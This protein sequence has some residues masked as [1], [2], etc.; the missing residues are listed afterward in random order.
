VIQVLRRTSPLALLATLAVA[1]AGCGTPR[2]DNGEPGG[3]ACQTCHGGLSG[4][5]APPR[6]TT[7][8][9]STGAL[10]VGAHQ[11]HLAD[12]AFRK[13]VACGECH[14][15]PR[16]TD[17]A[18]GVVDVVFG[19]LATHGGAPAAFA[20]D[21]PTG[22]CSGVY[23]H[24]GSLASNAV[25][26][27]PTWNAAAP[28]PLGCT[29]CHGAPPSS[30]FA[31]NT[32]CHAC[33]PATVKADGTIDVAGGHHIDGVVDVRNDLA[34]DACH[35]AP[36]DTGAHRAHVGAVD[37]ATLTYG[38]EWRAETFG[39]PVSAFT[40]GCGACHPKDASK[41]RNGKVD[42][43][44]TAAAGAPG[45]LR[46]LNGPGA[47]YAGGSCS[48]VYCHSS[49][50][51][52]PAFTASPGWT[53][54]AT[55]GCGGCHGDPP[56][57]P[58]GGPGSATANSHIFLNYLGREGGH[59]AGLPGPTYHGVRHG[60]PTTRPAELAAPITCQTCHAGTV[61]PSNVLPGGAFYAD[62][63]ITTRLA[64]GD[65]ARLSDPAWKATQCVTCPG[66][67]GGP[68]A[69]A[70]RTLPLK[71]VNGTR[72]VAF[73]GRTLADLPAGFYAGLGAAAPSRPYFM[74]GATIYTAYVLGAG[75]GW[76][77]A[78]PP[79]VAGER[80]T[81][82]YRLGNAGFAPATQTC[83]SVACHFDNA[84]RWGQKD[85]EVASASTCTGCHGN[86]PANGQLA[87]LATT[88]GYACAVCH[89]STVDGKNAIGAGHLNGVKDVVF[90]GAGVGTW[91]GTNCT[92]V[93]H[94][95][96]AP[97]AWR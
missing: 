35:G 89:A 75:A 40:F 60:S 49:G 42:V 50:Q 70:G 82:S 88:Q 2:N 25:K 5:A 93:C 65:Q 83:S 38:K 30:H 27:R 19:T 97:R 8:E 33:H 23:C 22:S 91:D 48:G 12:S 58:N 32:D 21:G 92:A 37:V 62:T 79:P 90:I 26:P 18:N 94:I 56:S 6:A 36:P 16:T 76:D 11:A 45:E 77:P 57:Y 7:G 9:T 17:H 28:A 53:S 81:L 34:C 86:P 10:R 54:G 80:R 69:A 44:L 74:T 39:A 55:L 43:E 78:A 95:P 67:G 96:N 24:G 71:H 52:S 87:F 14:V 59:Y 63:G 29:S 46:S 15:V 20:V 64:G 41:H 85:F 68:A 31:G 73:D 66:A 1:A 3:P 84:V 4:N 47:A 61:D 72:D 13:A 51:A